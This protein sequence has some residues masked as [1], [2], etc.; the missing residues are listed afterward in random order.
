M[1]FVEVP[2]RVHEAELERI[3]TQYGSSLLRMCY[4]YLRDA[5]LAEDAVQ[6]TFLKACNKL[7]SFRHESSEQSWLMRIAINTCKDYLR[8]AWFRRVDR[9]V[10]LESLPDAAQE[11]AMSDSTVV[12]EVMRLPAKYKDVVLLRYYQEM[13]LK[14]VGET[15]G[16]PI[17]TVKS[18]LKHANKMLHQRLERWYFDE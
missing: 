6:D 12:E 17:D 8:M 13:K 9:R 18:R 2:N 5:S 10:S 16:I 11:P 15:L 7:G 3:M 4:L 14:Q 1:N